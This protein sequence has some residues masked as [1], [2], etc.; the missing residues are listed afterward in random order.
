M[1]YLVTWNCT[2]IANGEIIRRLMK[3]NSEMNR[4]TPLIV[5]PEEILDTLGDNE[6]EK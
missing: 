1:D 3:V 6:Y 2:H 4:H 5:T